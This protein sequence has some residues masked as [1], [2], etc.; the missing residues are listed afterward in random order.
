M[1]LHILTQQRPLQ[2]RTQQVAQDI[3]DAVSVTFEGWDMSVSVHE[4]VYNPQS[5]DEMSRQLGCFEVSLIWQ[6]GSLS[7]PLVSLPFPRSPFSGKAGLLSSPFPPCPLSLNARVWAYSQRCSNSPVIDSI[8]LSQVDGEARSALLH[9][10]TRKSSFPDIFQLLSHLLCLLSNRQKGH[11]DP[12]YSGGGQ[13]SHM[14]EATDAA[15]ER[16][17]G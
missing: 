7:V 17:G 13:S 8:S 16:K 15:E 9:S 2:F 10:K 6:V 12:V 14:A 4:L 5:A 11:N 1:P 3:R